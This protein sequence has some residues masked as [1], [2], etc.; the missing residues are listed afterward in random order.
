M[1]NYEGTLDVSKLDGTAHARFIR[2]TNDFSRNLENHIAAIS[3]HFI[4][5]SSHPPTSSHLR[6]MAVGIPDRVWDV[7]DIVK[8]LDEKPDKPN[9]QDDAHYGPALGFDPLGRR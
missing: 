8:L 3:L 2:L 9:Y 6:A 7:A 5:L 1:P 4:T